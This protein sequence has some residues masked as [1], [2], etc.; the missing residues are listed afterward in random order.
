MKRYY[1]IQLII[2]TCIIILGLLINF[3]P[4]IVS[5]NPTMTFYLLM[6]FYS[7]L[8]LLEYL[9]GGETKESL[10][11]FICAGVCAFSGC[12]LYDLSPDYVISITLIGWVLMIAIIKIMNLESIYKTK[13]RLFII[14]IGS[15]SFL[16][17]MGLLISINIYFNI[18]AI[19]YML[20]ALFLSYGLVELLTDMLD[21]LS[22]DIK[23]KKESEV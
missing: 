12:F 4:K 7:V 6:A 2:D 13:S 5:I 1:S 14:K 23:F 8:E 17:L 16:V 20:G 22:N 9:F 21:Y 15:M 11:L 19:G 3:F 10:Y 18:S